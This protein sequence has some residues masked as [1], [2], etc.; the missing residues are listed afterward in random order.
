MSKSK[1]W[2]T[3]L[4]RKRFASGKLT[5]GKL[6]ELIKDMPDEALVEYHSWEEICGCCLGN[7]TMEDVWKHPV[8]GIL[9]PGHVPALVL[10]PGYDYDSRR[11]QPEG[12]KG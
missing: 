10:N 4:E 3:P 1:P 9:K 7:Y 11:P 12:W 8:D 6:R 5:I 2:D